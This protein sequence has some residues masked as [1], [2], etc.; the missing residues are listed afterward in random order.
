MRFTKITWCNEYKGA[1]S[2]LLWLRGHTT[3][4]SV[5]VVGQ[6]VAATFSAAK[7]VFLLGD[8]GSYSHFRNQRLLI[9]TFDRP[10]TFSPCGTRCKWSNDGRL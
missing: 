4:M 6:R 9:T 1:D 10:Y 3:H 7:R 5:F 8:A 2:V